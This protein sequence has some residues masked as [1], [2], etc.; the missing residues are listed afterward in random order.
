MFYARD[1]VEVAESLLGAV[2][3][4]HN[5]GLVMSGVIT[6][7]EAYRHS[8]DPASHAY[9]RPTPRNRI[10]FGTV[11]MAY[12]YFTYGMHFCFNVTARDPR[13]GAGAVLLRGL[14]PERGVEGMMKNRKTTNLGILADGPAKLAQALGITT[15]QYGEDLTVGAGLY[16][17]GNPDYDKT[18]RKITKAPRVGIKKAT[19]R[20]W[21][22]KLDI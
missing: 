2:L 3:V 22:F 16:V 1:T 8:D 19:D 6:E 18:R 14:L 17:T 4:H 13:V 9:R 12:V 15:K 5:S 11:G 7:T 20:L 21:N 10:M